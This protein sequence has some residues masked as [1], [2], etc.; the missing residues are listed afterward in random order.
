MPRLPSV[1]DLGQRPTPSAPS[2]VTQR[3]V[4]QTGG[5]EYEAVQRSANVFSN[6]LAE[7][8]D[9]VDRT[10]A[11]EAFNQLRSQQLDL[12]IGDDGFRNKKGSSAVNSNLLT[13]YQDRFDGVAKSIEDS[14]GNDDQKRL[15]RSRADV[16][17]LQFKEDILRHVA[18]EADVQA[19]QTFAGTLDV[20]TRNATVRYDEPASI[21]LSMERINQAIDSE[22]ERNKWAPEYAQAQKRDA[23][24]KVNAGVIGT[25]LAAGNIVYA[26]QWFDDHR[27]N[28][29][30]SVAATLERSVADAEQKELANGYRTDY[31]NNRDS[32][33]GLKGLESVVSRDKKLSEDRKNVLLNSI[34]SRMDVLENRNRMQR[35]NQIREISSQLDK[36]EAMT[37]KGFEITPDQILQVMAMTRGTELEDKG[38][39]LIQTAIATNQFRVASPLQ[40]EQMVNNLEANIRRSPTP[41]KVDL[42][43]KYKSIA[44]NQSKMIK[45]TPVEFAYQQGIANQPIIDISNP[46][47]SAE[48][49]QYQAHVAKGVSAD[50]GAPLKPLMSQQVNEITRFLKNSTTDKKIEWLGSFKRSLGDDNASY[51]AAMGQIAKDDPVTAIAGDFAGKGRDQQARLILEG[52]ALL[53]PPTQEDGRPAQGK[54]WPMPPQ[55][56]IN[57][58]FQDFEGEAFVSSPDYR[59]AVLQASMAV[60]AKMAQEQNINDGELDDDLFEDA[61]KIV[62]GDI[63]KYNGVKTIVPYGMNPSDFEDEIKRRINYMD[64]TDRFAPGMN[65]DK[66]LDFPLETIGDGKYLMSTGTGYVVDKEGKPIVIDFNQEMRAVRGI[67]KQ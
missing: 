65:A 5:V 57:E 28:I 3:N 21:A 30:P 19:K 62:A 12:T 56:D 46:E 22:A 31:L 16:S 33:D 54:L 53:R 17:N 1:I 42:L 14:L 36:Y 20:E 38:K 41:D 11:E 40:K 47:N 45:E 66:A 49:M 63:E 67:I 8:K 7:Y 29:D 10:R 26:K 25:A 15:F 55:K 52:Q 44:D 37:L 23:A 18:A 24:S 59:N 48:E 43:G 2:G 13:T 61:I 39:S 64:I 32:F 58:I 35:D 60:Y 34:L 27:D 51:V 6:M 4:A 9:R 50:Y